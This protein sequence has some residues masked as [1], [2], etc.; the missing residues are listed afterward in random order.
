MTLSVSQNFTAIAYGMFAS[1]HATGGTAPYVYSVVAGGAG[2]SINSS[3]GSYTAPVISDSDPVKAFDTI[4][5]VDALAATV[6]AQIMV[7]SPLLLFCDIIRR[8][9]GLATDRVYLW[10]QKLMQPS[11]NGLYIAISVGSSRPFG[12]TNREVNGV[13]VQSV[14]MQDTV[15]MD[16]IS[17][18]PAARDRRGEVIMALNSQYS[19]QQQ[20]GNSFGIGILSNNFLNLSHVDGAAIPYRYQISCKL[21]Y[22]VTK[23]KASA[24]FDTFADPEVSTDPES[25]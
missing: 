10:D 4:Q 13:Q 8:E 15:T 2:G 6:T 21:I 14:N 3:T 25:P 19:Q 1:F 20:E 18:G 17:R 7:G 5:V 9:M 16:I 12:N 23:L 22:F 24:Y 11:D